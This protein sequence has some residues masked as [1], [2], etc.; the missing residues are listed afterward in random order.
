MSPQRC[1]KLLLFTFY[2]LS[3]QRFSKLLPFTFYLLS[4]QRF[5]KLLH[6]TF[7]L[8]SP[9]RFSKLLHFT[10][11]LLSHLDAS[12]KWS[13]SLQ[14]TGPIWLGRLKWREF[15]MNFAS[16]FTGVSFSD[17]LRP[18][19]F[20]TRTKNSLPTYFKFSGSWWIEMVKS[21]LL[22]GKTISTLQRYLLASKTDEICLFFLVRECRWQ[23]SH[24]YSGF[25][26]P[27]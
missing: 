23:W 7:Y 12:S 22:G 10:F 11:Y 19:F 4:P 27:P 6:F 8:I 21:K 25:G 9:Q 2:L 15:R 16:Y 5:S 17:L 18:V 13:P 3:P 24:S 14:A 1:S 20:P 26:P